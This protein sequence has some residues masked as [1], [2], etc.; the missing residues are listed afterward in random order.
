M[1]QTKIIGGGV[2]G[3]GSELGVDPGFF[4]ARVVQRPLDYSSTGRLLGH[5]RLG[6]N[7]VAAGL[8]ASGAVLFSM[9]WTDPTSSF[10][11]LRASIGIHVVTA[12]TAQ[13]MQPLQF[14]VVRNYTTN[15]TTNVTPVSFTGTDV[16][17]GKVRTVMGQSGLAQGQ[18]GRASAVAGILGGVGTMDVIPAA[19]V[20][21]S[22]FTT[23]GT[24]VQDME[25]FPDPQNY[26]HPLIFS[27]N[28]GFRILWGATALATG[29]ASVLL[30]LTWAEVAIF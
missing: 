30:N 11:L 15:E 20:T 7:T 4:A 5:Y 10:V 25:F 23:L 22:L 26:G 2:F 24:N 6:F 27:A 1:A 3:A 29:S 14:R 16:N 18:L 13:Q 28:E 21:P 8:W 19:I 17:T 9:R 12:I